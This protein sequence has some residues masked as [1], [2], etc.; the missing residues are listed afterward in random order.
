M[1]TISVPFQFSEG[2][3]NTTND[4]HKKARQQIIDVLMTGKY[5]R[6]MAP[7]YGADAQSLTFNA[8]NSLEVADFKEEAIAKIN[9]HCSG[10]EVSDF[11][12]SASPPDGMGGSDDGTMMYVTASYR[13]FGDPTTSTVSVNLTNPT[14]LNVFTPI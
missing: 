8:A 3:I 1:T 2:S 10:S 4:P 11:T 9:R 14:H 6:V 12:V 7:G 13:L 5:E